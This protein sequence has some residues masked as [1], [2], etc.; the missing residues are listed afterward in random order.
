[1]LSISMKTL[2]WF[3]SLASLI[4]QVLAATCEVA[5]GTS[6]DTAAIK[7][8]LSSCNNGGTVSLSYDPY[9]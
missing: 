3:S 9:P 1:M 2:A 4:P 5:G 8:A 6:D 7:A